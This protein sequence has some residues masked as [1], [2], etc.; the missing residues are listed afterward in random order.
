[1]V[2]GLLLGS[3]LRC[4][5]KRDQGPPP[6]PPLEA[7]AP[8]PEQPATVVLGTPNGGEDSLTTISAVLD[9]SR[10]LLRHDFQVAPHRLASFQIVNVRQGRIQASFP[11]PARWVQYATD[12]H[13]M[14][15]VGCVVDDTTATAQDCLWSLEDDTIELLPTPAS[16]SRWNLDSKSVIQGKQLD[17][18]GR[19]VPDWR[20]Y[21]DTPFGYALKFDSNPPV[22][23]VLNPARRELARFR[24]SEWKRFALAD[25]GD[26]LATLGDR[27]I[28]IYDV[29]AQKLSALI[30][31]DGID[32]GALE[33]AKLAARGDNVSLQVGEQVHF[34]RRTGEKL[35]VLPEPT[36]PDGYEQHGRLEQS[37]LS[38]DGTR[39]SRAQPLDRKGRKNRVGAL[40]L[41]TWSVERCEEIYSRTVDH[42]MRPNW[43]MDHAQVAFVHRRGNQ[44]YLRLDSTLADDSVETQLTPLEYR[45]SAEDGL[46]LRASM[47]SDAA[48]KRIPL[49]GV[50][51]E[52]RTD[53]LP[54]P[55]GAEIKK[56]VLG[57]GLTEYSPD[58][59][60]EVVLVIADK[61]IG[62][63]SDVLLPEMMLPSPNGK[64]LFY[65]ED[66]YS[67]ETGKRVATFSRPFGS[68]VVFTNDQ[69]FAVSVGC[70]PIDEERPDDVPPCGYVVWDTQ[71][72]NPQQ[73][74]H[75]VRAEDP[76]W[77]AT[78]NEVG[79]MPNGRVFLEGFG[80][81][82]PVARRLLW[83][84]DDEF[85]G[86]PPDG[87]LVA[88]SDYPGDGDEIRIR[89]AEDGKQVATLSGVAIIT[90]I[91]DTHVLTG[92]TAGHLY[93][94]RRSDWTQLARVGPGGYLGK[95][96]ED[97]F[98][99]F[100]EMDRLGFLRVVDGKVLYQLHRLDGAPLT[101]DAAGRLFGDD[102][103]I[104]HFA[105][106]R[107][108]G[109]L[110]FAPLRPLDK[111]HPRRTA[112]NLLEEF[113]AD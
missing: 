97:R 73:A 11:H 92:D 13:K 64:F 5:S 61:E 62:L 1:M 42:A 70:E 12:G 83:K 55:C 27:S 78:M 28:E 72:A 23:T 45:F 101:F 109:D 30:S 47:S 33:K 8:L 90:W 20:P 57:Q 37:L 66:V 95:F 102:E 108:P 105:A 10:V 29:R 50:P 36:V 87:Q 21:L 25:E 6:V 31:L 16:D 112:V 100:T 19:L 22:L 51:P 85:A 56:R 63:N 69:R 68:R 75:L 84:D 53:A 67:C 94:Y 113:F 38:L 2:F 44:A 39:H 35:C 96:A 34:F 49:P 79:A 18:H 48:R 106:E 4:T 93:L 99:L 9:D 43:S 40:W 76:A 15:F 91:G 59:P 3:T 24:R 32:E 74:Y 111:R 7:S 52:P 54:S 65:F 80:L 81:Y 14:L 46:E 98:V 82:D 110:R 103:T 104:R 41:S 86:A 89:E 60:G 107:E 17:P 71:E 26:W 88:H 58:T 77:F